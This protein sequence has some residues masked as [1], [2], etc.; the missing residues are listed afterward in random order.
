MMAAMLSKSLA[1]HNK[2]ERIAFLLFAGALL[3]TFAGCFAAIGLRFQVGEYLLVIVFVCL[4]FLEVLF[5][6]NRELSEKHGVTFSLAMLPFLILWDMALVSPLSNKTFYALIICGTVVLNIVPLVLVR[7]SFI[8]RTQILQ[9][10]SRDINKGII[11]VAVVFCVLSIETIDT[12][13]RLDSDI[14]YYYLGQAAHWD[15]TFK[16]LFQFKLGG[17]LCEG[18]TLFALI[19]YYLTPGTAVGIRCIDI[20]L[21]VITFFLLAKICERLHIA[22]KKIAV[23]LTVALFAFNPLV[24]GI[25]YD[26][27]L[28]LPCTCF[29][30]WTCYS[31]IFERK[32]ATIGCALL[33]AFSKE[34]GLLMLVGIGLAYLMRW[35]SRSKK[36]GRISFSTMDVVLICAVMVP[37]MLYVGLTLSGQVWRQES[38]MNAPSNA[39]DTFAI[40]LANVEMKAKEIFIFNFSW[41]LS[42]G[43]IIGTA[44]GLLF[45][46]TLCRQRW[47]HRFVL[48]DASIVA[49]P[50]LIIF[51]FQFLYVTY[52]HYRYVLPCTLGLCLLFSYVLSRALPCYKGKHGSMLRSGVVYCC[53]LGAV[54]TLFLLESFFT[55]DPLSMKFGRTVNVGDGQI[56]TTRTFIRGKDNE[57]RTFDETSDI[58][59]NF[60][61]TQSA[62]Y[63]RQYMYFENVFNKA[64]Q[65]IHYDDKTMILIAPIF[66]SGSSDP[67]MTWISLFG[68]WYQT[69]LY[70]DFANGRATD[71]PEYPKLNMQIATN[72]NIDDLSRYERVFLFGFSYNDNFDMGNYLK[73]FDISDHF[74]ITE[75][76]WMID[77]YELEKPY[78]IESTDPVVVDVSAVGR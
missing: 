41:V 72:I 77:V 47:L 56:L 62:I 37:I 78:V 7:T 5:L 1:N 29:F 16:A 43:I 49:V 21:C 25:I 19:G 45:R 28:D 67:D 64:L 59:N 75:R 74:S 9:F 6:V 34:P 27:N 15:F 38:V 60:T 8:K 40:N 68:Q 18:Y 14:Y 4:F 13:T 63:N 58:F 61:L 54:G 24:L 69:D 12:W 42:F 2:I 17:H 65:D 20:G 33:L 76:Q 71:N 36:E 66:S 23:A 31:V 53:I 3:S 11:I 26:I 32:T 50:L 30:V 73:Q 46:K 51:A 52:C 35:I 48:G 55:I 70:Y 44:V 22:D 57:A 39:M 10:V